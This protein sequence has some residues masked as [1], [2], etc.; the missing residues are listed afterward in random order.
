M[1]TVEVKG[2]GVLLANVAGTVRAVRD[3]CPHEEVPLSKGELE[4]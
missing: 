4:G 3:R 1:T 2:V